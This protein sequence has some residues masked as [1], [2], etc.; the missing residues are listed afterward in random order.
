MT[1][2]ELGRLMAEMRAELK[3][4]IAALKED[5][6]GLKVYQETEAARCPYRESIARAANNTAR[7][8]R[9]EQGGLAGGGVTVIAGI[10]FAVGRAAGWW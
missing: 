8:T 10:V 6:V 3:E 4:D 2:D 5:I 1:M 9:L 7:L